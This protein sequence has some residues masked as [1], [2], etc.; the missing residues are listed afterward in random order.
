MSGQRWK[1]LRSRFESCGFERMKAKDRLLDTLNEASDFVKA[2]IG[3]RDQKE[4]ELNASQAVAAFP[5]FYTARRLFGELSKA[6]EE[7]LWGLGQ[8]RAPLMRFV[9]MGGVYRYGFSRW[10]D[11]AMWREVQVFKVQW[12]AF[13]E[14][15]FAKNQGVNA[16]PSIESLW[17]DA[18]SGQV[19]MDEVLQTFDEMLFANLDVTTHVLSW[20]VVLLAKEKRI[21]EHVREDIA[22]NRSDIQSYVASKDTLLHCSLL[23]TLRLRPV[24]AF[25]IPEFS[26]VEKQLGGFTVPAKTSV[27]VDTI[28]INIRNA[29]WGHDSNRFNPTRFASIKLSELR[30]NLF[31]FGFGVRKC[32]G[33]HDAELLIKSFMFEMLQQYD[34]SL[35]SS[36]MDLDGSQSNWVPVANLAVRLQR[37]D[38]L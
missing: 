16:T 3:A 37:R 28:A 17:R 22:A 30:Y 4:A 26:L 24:S 1:T 13:C 11:R 27:I 6:D 8:Q 12:R 34:L 10:W 23:E 38:S 25:T 32:L 29:F 5:F 14:R 21:Q 19:S 18:R 2:L 35:T 7:E 20:Y 33:Q 31:T 36:G 15:A 9:L